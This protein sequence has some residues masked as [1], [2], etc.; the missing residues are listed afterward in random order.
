VSDKPTATAIKPA[1]TKPVVKAAAKPIAKSKPAIKAKP[2]PKSTPKAAV[3]SAPKE[4]SEEISFDDIPDQIN[5]D[6]LEDF[7]IRQPDRS[8]TETF[9]SS[10]QLDDSIFSMQ[11]NTK[12]SRYSLNNQGGDIDFDLDSD[13]GDDF[14]T[15]NFGSNNDNSDES[16][17]SDLLEEDNKSSL[18]PAAD[19]ESWTDALLDVDDDLIEDI[20]MSFTKANVAKEEDDF[21]PSLEDEPQ[22]DQFHLGGD[23]HFE[24]EA[25]EI[26]L[27]V[28]NSVN[29]LL[30]EPLN[31]TNKSKKKVAKVQSASFT[32][33]WLSASI[34]MIAAMI[35]QV[36]YFKF[37][38]WSR[39][40]DYRPTYA[41]V[42][43]LA[44]CQLPAIQDVT[45]MNT[46]HF[47]VRLHP[48]V[49]KA[50]YIDTLLINNAAY[51]QP[52]PDLNLVFTGLE[53]EIIASRRFK[54]K[55][56]LAGELAGAKVMPQKVPIHIAFEILN[57]G[58]EAV[59]Y[60]I[61]LAANH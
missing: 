49:K 34:I 8:N 12:P 22:A 37:D 51:Q 33:L 16:W 7:G 19:D 36:G 43:Q 61:E 46:Q 31:L 57:P 24:A 45:Q 41:M 23:D 5:D 32:W 3:K 40:P 28:T 35:A 54:P 52:F 60:R 10:L 27:S 20:D 2:A 38:A 11:E 15:D 42:C 21:V 6:P 56:Y 53:N 48:E 39:H 18:K 26:E 25:V 58:A 44:D 13:F 29:D 14:S 50:L 17:A 30:D 4:S 55:E 1:P 59:S 9:D 47:M